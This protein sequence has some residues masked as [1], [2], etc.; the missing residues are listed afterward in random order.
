MYFQ[1]RLSMVFNTIPA[2]SQ[3]PVLIVDGEKQPK[4]NIVNRQY[5]DLLKYQQDY[6]RYQ[7]NKVCKC[8]YWAQLYFNRIDLHSKLPVNN[9]AF[10]TVFNTHTGVFGGTDFNGDDRTY[11]FPPAVADSFAGFFK[12]IQ[13][14][15]HFQMGVIY[16]FMHALYQVVKLIYFKFESVPFTNTEPSFRTSDKKI[17]TTRIL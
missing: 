14:L 6:A 7:Q 3:K 5:L 2:F 8:M 15:Y 1:P 10:N 4:Q 17:T 16:I 13:Q 11:L 12:K 9:S